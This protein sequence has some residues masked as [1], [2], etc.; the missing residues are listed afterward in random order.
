VQK[1]ISATQKGWQ[2]AIE[3]PDEA[4]LMTLDYQPEGEKSSPEHLK[5][6]MHVSVPLINTGNS[7]LGYM[8]I[9]ALNN[10]YNIL[11]AQEVISSPFDFTD[12]FTN[13]FVQGGGS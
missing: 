7:Y 5:Y 10:T 13:E 12:S 9:N 6:V 8:D 2:S 4:A 11:L 1:F 3:N